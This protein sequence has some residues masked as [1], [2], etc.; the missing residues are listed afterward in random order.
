MMLQQNVQ[1]MIVVF[2]CWS[3]VGRSDARTRCR[4]DAILDGRGVAIPV[5]EDAVAAQSHGVAARVFKLK[6]C[7]KMGILFNLNII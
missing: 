2:A 1:L 3:P 7:L 5:V 6:N 4:N